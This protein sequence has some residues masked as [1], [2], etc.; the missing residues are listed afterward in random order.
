MRTSLR[1]AALSLARAE[2]GDLALSELWRKRPIAIAWVR[3][4]G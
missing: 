4:F 2:G 3:H 1:L